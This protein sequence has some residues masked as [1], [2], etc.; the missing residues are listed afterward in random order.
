MYNDPNQFPSFSTRYRSLDSLV[1]GDDAII[2]S[3]ETLGLVERFVPPADNPV[4]QDFF[5]SGQALF[6]GLPACR[7][8]GKYTSQGG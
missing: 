1:G 8:P 5:G 4:P 6:Y 2:S 3:G 7:T